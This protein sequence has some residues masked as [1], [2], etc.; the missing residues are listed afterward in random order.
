MEKGQMNPELITYLPGMT[1]ICYQDMIDAVRTKNMPAGSTYEDFQT[2][3]FSMKLSANQY[4]NWNIVYICL[5]IE[6]KARFKRK[7]AC[8]YDYCKY[9][10]RSL[11]KRDRQKKFSL[12]TFIIKLITY[13][14]IYCSIY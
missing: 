11:D 13:M 12:K 9:F 7:C 10:F 1:I 2:L 8:L 6:I 4:M 14:S 5:P 3:E